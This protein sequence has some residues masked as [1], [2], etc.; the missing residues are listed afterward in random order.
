MTGLISI[1]LAKPQDAEILAN[2]SKR[3]FD[4][5]VD[6]GAPGPGGPDGYDSVEAHRRDTKSERT[7]YWKFLFNGQIVG[8]TRVYKVSEE[9]AYIYGV[10]IDP[11][12]HRKGIGTGTFRLIESN[13]PKVKKW[14]LDTPEWNVRTKGF[15]E[16]IGFR[17]EGILRWV[18]VFDLRYYVKI[19]DDSYEPSYVLIKDLQDGMKGLKI[20]GRIEE[21]SETRDVISKDGKPLQVANVTFTDETGSVKLVLWNDTIRQV[22]EGEDIILENAYVN[23][24]KGNLQLGVSRQGQIIVIRT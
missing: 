10:F 6:V 20:K 15:Y 14:T 5:D 24:Y 13:Y 8:G 9:H 19:T 1:E 23:A 22:N 16:K 7:D 18:P 21:V 17:Q 12:F 2:I 11:E 3:A 4:S